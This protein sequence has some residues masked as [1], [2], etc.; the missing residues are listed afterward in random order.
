VT[1][2]PAASVS[3][4]PASPGGRCLRILELR[5]VWG[6]G[7][8]PEKT[9]LL[10][11][12]QADPSRY[13][14]TVCYIRDERDT[15][16]NIDQRAKDLGVEY[17]DVRERNSFDWRVFPALRRI[18]RE[19]GI[20]IVHAHDYK[21]DLLALLLARAENVIP[22]S[23]AH[24]FSGMSRKDR[25]YYFVDRRLLARFPRVVV[26]SGR[27]KQ[28]LLDA[29]ARPGR[30]TVIPNSVDHRQFQ[31]E[32]AR[33]RAEARTRLQA[34]PE[35][36]V[37]GT[38]GR[39]EEVKRLD[40][41]L[42][43]FAPIAREHP[44]AV[45]AVVGDGPLKD[46]LHAQAARLGLTARCRF[47]GHQSDVRLLLHGFDAYAQ[48]SVSEGSPNAVLEA[49]AMS[50]PVVATDA[51][52]TTD[53]MDHGVHGLIVPPLDVDAL[54]AGI[55]SLMTDTAGARTRA[56]AARARVEDELS[57]ERRMRR[58]ETIYD[59]LAADRDARVRP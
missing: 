22:F 7:G 5:S 20:D 4:E 36:F 38:V 43:A 23:T 3:L 39:L 28:E 46:A 56:I 6:T 55:A 54:R 9:I 35:Q 16:F 57:F 18:I 49:M 1:A 26:V 11:A 50:I 58:L 31:R 44:H 21:T 34:S 52:G 29:G 15:V 41:L 30:V 47:M 45:L 51:G 42:D 32:D 25:A 19:R 40:L 48:S 13:A 17:V 10:G 8:G 14:V 27:L 59:D 33:W 53:I 2:P 24:G 37:I 12:A